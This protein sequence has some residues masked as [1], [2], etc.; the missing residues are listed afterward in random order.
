MP[1]PTPDGRLLCAS[2]CTYYA[3]ADG[4]LTTDPA[5]T[6]YAGAGFLAPPSAFVAGPES[7]NACL[8]GTLPD[9]VVLAF[10][11]TLPFDIHSRP[12]LRDWLNNFNAL[13]VSVAGFPGSVHPGFLGAMAS[14]WDRAVEEVGRQRVGPSAA[15]PLLVTGHSKGGAMASLAA[16]RLSQLNVPVRV[17]TFA[18]PKPGDAAFQ[19]AYNPLGI[20]TRYENADDLV[21]LL[22]ASTGGF[23][24]VLEKLPFI[25]SRFAGLARFDY[26]Q[27]GVLR[28]IDASGD[29]EAETPTLAAER[30]LSLIQLIL[31][32]RFNQIA[33]DHSIGCGS[34]YMTGVCPAG[35]CPPTLP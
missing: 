18:A 28:Y 1:A 25:G 6:Y 13:P 24:D 7:I 32:G 12:T 10:R 21:P 33:A 29:I 22:P 5:D 31:W 30:A 4:P 17:V 8:V 23:L 15:V 35:V 34:G 3:T 9:G 20:H 27:V 11:G 16:W 26:Q 14:L 19:A 2:N